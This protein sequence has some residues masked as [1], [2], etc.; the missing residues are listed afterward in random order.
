MTEGYIGHKKGIVKLTKFKV[1]EIHGYKYIWNYSDNEKLH[2]LDNF[3][4]KRMRH[5]CKP[6]TPLQIE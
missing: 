2:E 5:T 3:K 6:T 4:S 1:H